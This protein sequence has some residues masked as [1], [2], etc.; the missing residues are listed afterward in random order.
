MYIDNKENAAS[1]LTRRFLGESGLGQHGVRIHLILQ[2]NWQRTYSQF[3]RA[4]FSFTAPQ[5]KICLVFTEIRRNAAV[6]SQ[7]R[8]YIAQM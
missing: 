7:M 6:L 2:E 4:F 1:F 3:S 5:S 8:S